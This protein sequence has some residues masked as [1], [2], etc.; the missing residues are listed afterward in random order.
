MD[1]TGVAALLAL[2][3]IPVSVLLT[4]WQMRAALRQ[5]EAGHH[6]AMEVAAANH[7][8]ALEAAEAGHRHALE[9]ARAQTRMERARW[10]AETRRVEYRFLQN[11]LAQY[12]RVL[13]AAEP[14][15]E[16]VV[17]AFDEVHHGV[18]LIEAVGPEEVHRLAARILTACRVPAAAYQ[19]GAA[20]SP[21]DRERWWARIKTLRHD[22]HDTTKK[23]LDEP[24][25]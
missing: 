14:L 2:A 22:F 9:L 6:T 17:S 11:S 18:N 3:G 25:Q 8:S 15:P 21:D 7:R 16:E 5:T 20:P 1:A 12:R 10:L 24:W 23:A 19:F 13:M 4:R